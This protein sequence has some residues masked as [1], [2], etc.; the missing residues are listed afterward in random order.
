MLKVKYLIFSILQS[1]K[2]KME[3]VSSFVREKEFLRGDW[4]FMQ[5]CPKVREKFRKV[6]RRFYNQ[7]GRKKVSK[8][9]LVVKTPWDFHKSNCS[10]ELG[11][12]DPEKLTLVTNNSYHIAPIYPLFAQRT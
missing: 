4:N 11:G 1:D 5:I 9:R 8:G 10:V 2:E 12:L 3:L 7:A 6:C